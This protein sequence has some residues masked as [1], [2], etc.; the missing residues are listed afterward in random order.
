[1][2]NSLAALGIET[3]VLHRKRAGPKRTRVF[4]EAVLN[5]PQVGQRLEPLGETTLLHAFRVRPTD[6][7]HEDFA[8]LGPGASEAPIEGL[9]P[10]TWIDF[11]MTN[12]GTDTFRH[13]SPLEPSDLLIQW[14]DEEGTVARRDPHRVLL[15]IALGPGGQ[16]QFRVRALAPPE[17]G[18][19][20]VTMARAESPN[21]P[22]TRRTVDLPRLED[23]MS[24]NQLAFHVHHQFLKYEVT[25]LGY[26]EAFPPEDEIEVLLAP[27]VEGAAALQE[28][29]TLDAHW[30]H[31]SG[32]RETQRIKTEVRASELP[33]RAHLRLEIPPEIGLHG[34]LLTPPDEPRTILG[35]RLVFPDVATVRSLDTESQE[36]ASDEARD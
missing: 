4:E 21:R 23:I 30:A 36:A 22:L 12:Q 29:E 24:P 18:V 15:P 16:M 1:M 2:K 26:E 8:L 35:G 7:I 32:S 6:E 25:P 11:T 20:Q 5:D 27:G 19:Y 28:L 3:I 31:V 17:P 33:G 14:I 10:R 9:S 13:P 34:L